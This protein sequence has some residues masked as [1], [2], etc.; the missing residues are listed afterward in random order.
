MTVKQVIQD[1]II[2]HR[3]VKLKGHTMTYTFLDIALDVLKTAEKPLKY[4]EIWEMGVEAGLATKINISGKTPWQTLGARL[5]VDVRDNPNTRFVKIGSRPTRF[6]LKERKN[7]ISSDTI[8]KIEVEEYKITKESTNW[9]ERELHP[10]LAYFVYANP[11]FGRGK[12]VR[13]KTIFH[14]RSKKNGYSEWLYPDMVGFYLPLEDWEAEIIEFGK[15]SD[16]NLVKLYSFEIKKT[17][18]KGNYR[19]SFFQAVSNSSWANE[20]YLVTTEI[21]QDDDLISELE[22]L[23]LSFG[24]GII[25]LNLDD[26]DSSNVIFPAIPKKNYDWETMNKIC[27]QNKDFRRFIQDVKIDFESRRI[28]K[29]EY[30]EIIDDPGS[31]IEKM[32]KSR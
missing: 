24:I 5:Y 25:Q 12:E 11:S 15:I 17:L 13:S 2:S 7:Q 9:H 16:N 31:H 26:F 23:T 6:F 3:K 18:S 1:H 32:R 14:E 21:T 4:Q 10:L 27:S 20:G 29:S 8:E 30:D 22:R 28:H 19:E